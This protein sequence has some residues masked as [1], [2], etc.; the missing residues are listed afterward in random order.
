M[1]NDNFIKCR[2]GKEYEIFPALIKHKNKIRHYVV[3]FQQE[4]AIVNMLAP[5]MKKVN[6]ATK[7]RGRS[8]SG[9]YF[10]GRAF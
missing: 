4:S 3:K 10:H 7:K 1:D 6:Q 8:R 5:D 2:D 9:R